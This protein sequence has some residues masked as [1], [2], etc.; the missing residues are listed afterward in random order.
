MGIEFR[1]ASAEV[2]ANLADV[3]LCHHM[4]EHVTNPAE[5]L[6]EALRILAPG[7]SL[8]LY[9]P[10]EPQRQFRTYNA[11]EEN[12][13]LFAWNVQ[14]LAAL[15]ASCGFEIERARLEPF[16]YDRWAAELVGRLGGTPG[17]YR[18]AHRAV[19]FVGRRREICVVGYKPSAR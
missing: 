1:T 14:T 10:F 4:L 18:I 2:E 8:V 7:G 19:Q 12:M 5:V 9:T 16:G 17:A 15:A 11:Q 3:V 13:H 6:S